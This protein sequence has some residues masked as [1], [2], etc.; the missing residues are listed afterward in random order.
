M[1]HPVT[2]NSGLDG[3]FAL[4]LFGV[5][6]SCVLLVLFMGTSVYSRL[7]ERSQ[8]AYDRRT[9]VQYVTTKVRQVPS[10]ANVSVQDFDGVS[11]LTITEDI[12][13]ELFNTR[14]YCYD[15][16]LMELFTFADNE[17][18]PADG[19][20]IMPA[21]GFTASLDGDRLTLDIVDESGYESQLTLTLRGEGAPGEAE[22]LQAGAAAALASTSGNAG[23]A[24]GGSTAGGA[25]AGGSNAS[26]G[27]TASG[28]TAGGA[29]APS[30]ANASATTSSGQGVAA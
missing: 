5:F 24:A 4:L 15:G 3:V 16:W 22:A 10:A 1:R 28:A 12:N 9:S 17:F 11:A 6:A 18:N 30:P 2:R 27:A 25:G 23:T 13:G 20:R 19:Q 8:Q 7:T 14:I 21:Q 29:T 26:G